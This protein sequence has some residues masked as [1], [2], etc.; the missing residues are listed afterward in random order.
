M[1]IPKAKENNKENIE[2]IIPNNLF[3]FLIWGKILVDEKTVKIL[4][5]ISKAVK[6]LLNLSRDKWIRLGQFESKFT[7]F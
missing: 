5:K 7:N 2:V 4:L 1:I 3:F 6:Y